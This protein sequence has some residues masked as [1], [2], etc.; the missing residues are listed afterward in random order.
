MSDQILKAQENNYSSVEETKTSDQ[1]QQ[2][3]IVD[4]PDSYRLQYPASYDLRYVNPRSTVSHGGYVEIDLPQGTI[5]NECW[6]EW[7]LGELSSS[8]AYSEYPG[9][10]IIETIEL[11]SGPNQDESY[12]YDLVMNAISEHDPDLHALWQSV[13]GGTSFSSGTVISP[14]SL[15]F[16]ASNPFRSMY[17]EPGLDT[18]PA[19]SSLLLRLKLRDVS[20]YS[21]AGTSTITGKCFIET[22][23]STCPPSNKPYISTT[24]QTIKTSDDVATNTQTS[25]DIT[26]LSG[27]ITQL[28]VLDRLSADLDT[29]FDLWGSCQ[30][31][32]DVCYLRLNGKDHLN[33]IDTVESQRYYD[34]LKNDLRRNKSLA[35]I[36]F[37]MMPSARNSDF[38]HLDTTVYNDIRLIA[39]HQAGADARLDV[40]A[41]KQCRWEYVNGF[42]KKFE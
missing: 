12:D 13:S 41:V 6:M 10:S 38:G 33:A 14:I 32:V 21:S 2:V 18:R 28:Y 27:K 17:V 3:N 5:L 1:Q 39:R 19:K 9:M 22:I 11:R 23:E 15:F 36:S 42:L 20:G 8:G 29:N 37:S 16:S 31:D 26:P 35:T 24:Y 40:V 25:I 30:E 34:F 4:H 7:T